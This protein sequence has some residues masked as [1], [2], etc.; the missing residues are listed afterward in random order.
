MRS[1]R[2]F[3]Q[4]KPKGAQP[5]KEEV[6]RRAAAAVAAAAVTQEYKLGLYWL[7]EGGAAELQ[8]A[9]AT[10]R[11]SGGGSEEGGGG[12]LP[13]FRG[14]MLEDPKAKGTPRRKF[15]RQLYGNGTPCIVCSM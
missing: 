4:E 2:Q 8:Q 5:L 13:H 12:A 9:A 1:V 15:W 3:H 7:P 10:A 6:G 11:G 14:E